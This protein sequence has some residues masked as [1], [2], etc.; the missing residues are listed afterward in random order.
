MF[1]VCEGACDLLN[2]APSD[3]SCETVYLENVGVVDSC[4]VLGERWLGRQL[5]A[6]SSSWQTRQPVSH[7][8]AGPPE[9]LIR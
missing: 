4:I 3:W 9:K 2:G 5:D 1:N 6:V 7:H 8:R